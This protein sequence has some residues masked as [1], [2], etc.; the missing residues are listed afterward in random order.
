MIRKRYVFVFIVLVTVLII[1]INVSVVSA[2]TDFASSFSYLLYDNGAIKINTAEEFL[3][4]SKKIN[5]RSDIEVSGY[6]EKKTIN[7]A[8]ISISIMQDI[9]ISKVNYVGLGDKE[10][11]FRKNI[12]GNGHT[13]TVNISKADEVC[14]IINYGVDN[15][16][17]NL[18]VN[19]KIS[20]AT[21]GII[22]QY[23]YNGGGELYEI[24]S[25][26]QL[27]VTQN[28]G[29]LIGKI[30]GKEI[31]IK[32]ILIGDEY[33]EVNINASQGSCVGGIIGYSLSNSVKF[34]N[35]NVKLSIIGGAYFGGLIGKAEGNITANK[36]KI[37]ALIKDT[38]NGAGITSKCDELDIRYMDCN[39]NIEFINVKNAN[40][41]ANNVKNAELYNTN[42][43]KKAITQSLFGK[44]EELNLK[45]LKLYVDIKSNKE[46]DAAIAENCQIAKVSD[47][48][49]YGSIASKDYVGAFIGK[50]VNVN[51]EHCKVKA[52]LSANNVG[53]FVAISQQFKAKECES[54]IEINQAK[55]SGGVIAKSEKLTID[56]FAVTISSKS[57]ICAGIVAE[58][59]E[60]Q[61][62][63][64]KIKL[65]SEDECCGAVAKL[66]NIGESYIKNTVIKV[67][68]KSCG[69]GIIDSLVMEKGTLLINKCDV[70][71]ENNKSELCGIAIKKAQIGNVQYNTQYLN[72]TNQFCNSSN[73]S[74]I[75]EDNRLRIYNSIT[76]NIG[77]VVG[78]FTQNSDN[79][80]AI[81]EIKNNQIEGVLKANYC[82]GGIVAI[83][84]GGNAQFKIFENLM[85]AKI[86][87][88]SGIK[89]NC[90]AII[91]DV[92]N[93]SNTQIYENYLYGANC[94]SLTITE[95]GCFSSFDESILKATNYYEYIYDLSTP[96]IYNEKEF[97]PILSKNNDKVEWKRAENIEKLINS[98]VYYAN[99][100]LNNG[101]T[102]IV[103]FIIEKCNISQAAEKNYNQTPQSNE[104]N[105]EK[106]SPIIDYKDIKAEIYF[107]DNTS[108]ENPVDAG[109]YLFIAKGENDNFW[110]EY[111]S[112]FI[113]TKAKLPEIYMPY[114]EEVNNSKVYDGKP[115]DLKIIKPIENGIV[116]NIEYYGVNL[117]GNKYK[118]KNLPIDAGEYKAVININCS[119]N[120]NI[121]QKPP[122]RTFEFSIKAID[123]TISTTNNTIEYGEKIH[124]A[125]SVDG[126]I[127]DYF[128][129]LC[130]Y[131]TTQ[132]TAQ[133]AIALNEQNL[134][135]PG[136][137]KM[138]IKSKIISNKYNIKYKHPI[139]T[140]LKASQPTPE[141]MDIKLDIEFVVKNKTIFINTDNTTYQFDL[142]DNNNFMRT[143]RF[144]N[145]SVGKHTI[146]V[147]YAET[148][149]FK[150]SLPY[151][152]TITV[153]EPFYESVWFVII[154]PILAI[155][156]TI[157]IIYKR[158]K[159][160]KQKY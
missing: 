152:V 104:Y 80:N 118:S 106:Q 131:Q 55:L 107:Y 88:C 97:N 160:N 9:D 20:G 114:F 21:A 89:A 31:A 72:N 140:V 143:D 66:N 30:V 64:C 122:S 43:T 92:V 129:D 44:V 110:F 132:V 156:P 63:N 79:K 29:L 149:L 136:V 134:A 3:Y 45:H 150:A 123:L 48:E 82:A 39:S 54:N 126:L 22:G 16:V 14:G 81:I 47:C 105:G 85:A 46:Y 49:I 62:N 90:A 146:A 13:I 71:I 24:D 120:Y 109:K 78:T 93:D 32:D 25:K 159:S 26:L 18:K 98:G 50:A 127:E 60:T 6:G 28:G 8:D 158:K 52:N 144:Y 119:K 145:T 59:A 111:D 139:L 87:T 19:G 7:S 34:S 36:C 94:D 84:E 12:F 58:S 138:K 135:L 65:Y 15:I 57:G 38:T 1:F 137:Y 41:F 53:G 108:I 128:E 4:I 35:C 70:S 101:K 100:K 23:E 56:N 157:I 155:I 113:I 153:T 147:R 74:I 121:K 27:S 117:M 115:F 40:T 73:I 33:S 68:S 2:G 91:A 75:I 42:I 130:G 5:E 61:I 51:F 96:S 11:P 95:I 141:E 99:L 124:F 83:L 112:Y 151:Y 86:E 67:T 148:N 142:D 77:G 37:T 125:F 76:N 102:H 154:L 17:R 116:V 103:K 69:G 10:N 133:S